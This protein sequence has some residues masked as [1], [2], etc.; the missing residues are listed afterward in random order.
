MGSD[1]FTSNNEGFQL[2]SACW[3]VAVVFDMVP[4]GLDVTSNSR[5]EIVE[6]SGA[7]SATYELALI[8]AE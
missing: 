5:F 8:G 4:D 6:T 7:A 3:L 2:K 1:I